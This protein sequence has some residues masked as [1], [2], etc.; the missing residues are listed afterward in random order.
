MSFDFCGGFPFNHLTIYSFSCGVLAS[1]QY[2][3]VVLMLAC[4]K[5]F[6]RIGKGIP[7]IA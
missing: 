2:K 6:W 3:A 4:P 5:S 1:F 7:F